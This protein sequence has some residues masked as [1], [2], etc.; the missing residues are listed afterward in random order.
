MK[1]PAANGAFPEPEASRGRRQDEERQ[2]Y[3]TK[4]PS[5]SFLRVIPERGDK[6][7]AADALFEVPVAEQQRLVE[8][9]I[10]YAEQVRGAQLQLL[11]EHDGS[12]VAEKFL[13]QVQQLQEPFAAADAAADLPGRSSSSSSSSSG[14]AAANGL[15][16]GAAT[17]GRGAPG[18]APSGGG[19][20][21]GKGAPSSK[22][23]TVKF[24]L[25]EGGVSLLPLGPSGGPPRAPQQQSRQ[26]QGSHGDSETFGSSTTST[27]GEGEE[28]ETVFACQLESFL[29][30]AENEIGGP[31]GA[32][33]PE[34]QDGGPAAAAAAA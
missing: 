4:F 27:N 3:I 26:S 2:Q 9:F 10:E 13:Q 30:L 32:P 29:Q 1:G 25:I 31:R 20:L 28:E 15:S 19:P 5:S 6:L 34:Q 14:A 11:R 24:R 33:C 22:G 8:R 18:G 16:N 7:N 12:S 17:N 23:E 21:K